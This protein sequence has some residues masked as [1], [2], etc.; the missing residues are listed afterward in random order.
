MKQKDINV[1][2][3]NNNSYFFNGGT[4]NVK[5]LSRMFFLVSIVAITSSIHAHDEDTPALPG[6]LEDVVQLLNKQKSWLPVDGGLISRFQSILTDKNLRTLKLS[7]TMEDALAFAQHNFNDVTPFYSAWIYLNNFSK[8]VDA[9]LQD[10][11]AALVQ[12]SNEKATQNYTLLL[13]ALD[14][15]TKTSEA[16]MQHMTQHKAFAKQK[17]IYKRSVASKKVCEEHERLY[18]KFA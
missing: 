3:N 14:F 18:Y 6:Q 4:M 2:L 15:C 11:K 1:L 9:L 16:Y 17:K 7:P 8:K 10:V 13:E 5:S 12:T